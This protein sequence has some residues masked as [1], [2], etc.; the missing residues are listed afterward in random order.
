MKSQAVIAGVMTVAALVGACTHAAHVVPVP[1]HRPGTVTGLAQLCSGLPYT[2]L[3]PSPPPMGVYA[4][5]HGQTIA[6]QELPGIGGH[7]RLSLAPGRYVISA[8]KSGRPPKA[9]TLRSGE[10]LKVDFPNLCA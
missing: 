8:P 5:Q 9:I 3:R 2:M 4:Q 1:E 6:S 10:T 7:Y